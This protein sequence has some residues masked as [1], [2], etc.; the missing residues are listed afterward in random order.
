MQIFVL[1]DGESKGPMSTFQIREALSKGEISSGTL[2]WH[3]GQDGWKPLEEMPSLSTAVAT[4]ESPQSDD[5]DLEQG[6]NRTNVFSGN[7][8]H[9]NALSGMGESDQRKAR[10]TE[11]SLRFIARFFDFLLTFNLVAALGMAFGFLDL[12]FISQI[13]LVPWMT[14]GLCSLCIEAAILPIFGT[15]PGKALF[16]VRVLGPGDGKITP[17]A[18]LRRTFAIWWRG[19]AAFFPYFLPISMTLAYFDLI[20]R[21]HCAWDRDLGSQVVVGKLGFLSTLLRFFLAHVFLNLI[22]MTG[23]FAGGG[24]LE[25][26]Q[27]KLDAPSRSPGSLVSTI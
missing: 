17:D 27:K 21:G 3:R 4:P 12:E 7:G 14:I 13:R 10:A 26:L 20:T 23:Y 1:I 25:E 9:Q 18:A 24:T 6:A 19:L 22:V 8:V 5:S 16:Q 15:T 2:G 11:A